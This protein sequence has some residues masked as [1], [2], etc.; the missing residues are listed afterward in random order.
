[1]SSVYCPLVNTDPEASGSGQCH[2]CSV[3]CSKQTQKPQ[4]P[5]SVIRVVST[6]QNRPRSLRL[7]LVSSVFCPLVKTDTEASGSGYC[8]PCSVHWSKQTQKP[9]APVS[10]IRVLST[11]QNRPR[12]LRL[13]LVSSVFCPLVKTDPEASGSG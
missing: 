13:R 7:R 3:H 10:V 8:H 4:A 6:G 9:Q 12:R 11:G 5:V 1:M 2:P